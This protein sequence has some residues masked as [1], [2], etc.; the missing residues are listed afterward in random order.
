MPGLI[1]SVNRAVQ[2]IENRKLITKSQNHKKDKKHKFGQG[3]EIA[4]LYCSLE[5]SLWLFLRIFI[6]FAIFD[7]TG[8][9]SKGEC[10]CVTQASTEIAAGGEL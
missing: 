4:R 3:R 2:A 10:I 6:P 8:Q 9:L 5:H 7:F 1:V